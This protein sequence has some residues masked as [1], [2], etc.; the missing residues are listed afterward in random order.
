MVEDSN[1]KSML[2]NNMIEISKLRLNSKE[3]EKG[4]VSKEKEEEL[5]M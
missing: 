1:N 3:R 2:E 5:K 4:K